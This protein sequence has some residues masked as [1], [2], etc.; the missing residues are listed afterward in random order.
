MSGKTG[1]KS[2][3]L[4]LGIIGSLLADRIAVA[5]CEVAKLDYCALGKTYWE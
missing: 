4:G 3:V 2:A 1:G 5:G